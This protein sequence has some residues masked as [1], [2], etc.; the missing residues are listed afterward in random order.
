MKT[1]LLLSTLLVG[2]LGIVTAQAEMYRYKDESNQT[3]YSQ[4]KPAGSDSFTRVQPPP[5]PPSTAA[6]SRQEL[7]D[8]LGREQDAQQD[9]EKQAEE[10]EKTRQ[11][12]ERKQ[13]N[14]E[15][16]RNNLT[17][18]QN[19]SGYQRIMKDGKEVKFD[20]RQRQAEIRKAQEMIQKNCN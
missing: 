18:L 15:A 4:F 19:N 8:T 5:P 10:D 2:T 14:C 9:A 1:T 3:V 11:E 6:D 7:I 16:A 13:K 17:V 20:D 12:S